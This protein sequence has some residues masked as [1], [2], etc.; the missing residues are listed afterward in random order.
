MP[1]IWYVCVICKGAYCIS[2]MD[3]DQT[4]TLRSVK[5]DKFE[6]QANVKR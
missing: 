5:F 3:A 2:H 1:N 6:G 4:R